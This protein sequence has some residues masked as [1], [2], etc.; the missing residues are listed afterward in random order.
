[1]TSD[2][3]T[4]L[5]S[6]SN[7]CSPEEMP[8]VSVVTPS[9]NQRDYIV[10]A[11][12]SVLA[13]D[14]SNIEYIVLD[15]GSTDDTEHLLHQYNG[16]LYWEKHSNIGQAKTLNKGWK[17]SKGTILS[18]L[19]ADDALEPHAVRVAVQ[20]LL[21]HPETVL[22]YGDY[23]LMDWRGNTIRRVD[24]PDFDYLE[25]VANIVCQ[26]GPG[27]FF[28]REAFNRVGGWNPSL[29]QV[30]DYE[31]WLRLGLQGPFLR[32]PQPLARFRVHEQSQSY[33]E[34]SVEKSEECVSVIR[35]YFNR[36]DLPSEVRAVERQAYGSAHLIAA[37]FHLRGG[38]YQQM[39]A[40]LREAWKWRARTVMSPRGL[41]LLGNGILF[42][43][44]RLERSRTGRQR[45]SRRW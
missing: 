2:H 37:R 28:R 8:L 42:R 34:P 14:Y 32:I 44:R 6:V 16:R 40:H 41:A 38:R 7:D 18:Y 36:D 5:Y 43:I 21:K 9:F 30:P 45:G 35:E 10:E 23:Q 25:M 4:L 33:A 39:I 22:V 11:I 19:S 31:Y 17:I 12:E 26:P 27:V 24:A 13:Q 15:D 20:H 29:R 1:M 3:G